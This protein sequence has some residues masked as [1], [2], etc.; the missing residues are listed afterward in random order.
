MKTPPII[1]NVSALGF[2]CLL[3]GALSG[4]AL[5][6]S[7]GSPG[8]ESR[9]PLLRPIGVVS[10]SRNVQ[11]AEALVGD[12]QGYATL[13]MVQGGAAPMIILDYGRDVGG[14]PVFEVA[15]VTGVPKLQAIYSEAQ[16]Y[17]LPTGDGYPPTSSGS[18][19]TFAGEV[20]F[21]GN[22]SGAD[23]SRV[24]TYPLNRTGLVVNRLLQGGERFQAITLSGPGS[25]TLRQ[26]GMLSK[27][28]QSPVTD[29]RG[30]FACSDT[31]L[32]KIWDLGAYTVSLDQV[33]PRSIPTTWAATAEGVDVPGSEYTCY[34]AGTTWTDY[35]ATFEVKVLANE[36]SW[37]VHSLLASSGY[38]FVL[39]ADN[40][41]LDGAPNTLRAFEQ[42][43]KT[44]LGQAAV[45]DLKPSTWHAVKTVVT[46]TVLSAY[47]DGQ[48]ALR[49][50]VQAVAPSAVQ[51]LGSV[52]FGN[53]HGAEALFRNLSVTAAGGQT[54]YAS[55]LTDPSV[56]TSSRPAPTVYP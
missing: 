50:D 32:N 16:K 49:F 53:F 12:H 41:A 22:A 30:S 48:L 36:A 7:D 14:L 9:E 11:N 54:L 25:V 31:A 39:A 10:T 13:T 40:D 28:F 1:Q 42:S 29:N 46:G 21:V 17:L 52:G 3:L 56:G 35:A 23:L 15:A 24:D 51:P 38:R 4:F 5:A 33:P 37:L 44:P 43:S 8:P 2:G 19:Q 55:T 26:V 18:G 45:P 6:A 34:Q 20:S 47:L 27:T